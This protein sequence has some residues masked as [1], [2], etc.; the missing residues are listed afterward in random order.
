MAADPIVPIPPAT[1]LTYEQSAQLAN[2]VDFR[3]RVKIACLKFADKINLEATNIAAHNTR[4]KWAN[5]TMLNPDMRALQ[6]QP[7]T[8]IDAAVQTA[9]S[10]I[11]DDPLQASVEV[12]VEKML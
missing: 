10:E 6:V 11:A 1:K 2:D 8:V 12:T 7:S 3:G 9:G 4:L 5:E